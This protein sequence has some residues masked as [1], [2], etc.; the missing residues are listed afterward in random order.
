MN[1]SK[2]PLLLLH[3]AIGSSEQLLPLANELKEDFQVHVLDFSG[4][5]RSQNA[6]EL[7]SID[8]FA[9]D[10]LDYLREH[11]LSN[12]SVFGYSM[13][14][15]VALYLARYFPDKVGKIATLATKFHWDES[16]SQQE[17]Q[18]LIP[19]KIM[20]K[21]PAFAEVLN[22]RH[23]Q[24]DWKS[25]LRKTA[26]MMMAMGKKNPLSLQDYNGLEHTVLITLGNQDNMVSLDETTAVFRQL[27]NAS[28]LI[29]PDTKHPIEK[30][31]VSMFAHE[32]KLFFLH[33]RN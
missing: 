26:D 15:Y 5:G 13:G 11:Q 12:I 18:Q 32:L 16:T 17:S 3:G 2:T 6:C 21:I 1:N 10:V 33:E 4:H 22:Q 14:G 27:K 31:P 7:F 30:V 20:E 8:R 23:G 29:L 28:L 25:I 9:Q 19:E 24:N